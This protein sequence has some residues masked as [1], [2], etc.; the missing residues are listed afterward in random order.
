M[1]SQSLYVIPAE[2]RVRV[3]QLRIWQQHRAHI[4]TIMMIYVGE[5]SSNF[6]H[7]GTFVRLLQVKWQDD[8]F[9]YSFVIFVSLIR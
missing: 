9:H 2:A 7:A 1:N 5:L 6:F 4:I 3:V 8:K